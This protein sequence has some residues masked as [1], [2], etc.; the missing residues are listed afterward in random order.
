MSKDYEEFIEK[1]IARQ[2][3]AIENDMQVTIDVSMYPN[4][5]DFI[6]PIKG[7]IKEIN[8]YND[9]KIITF[10]TST[11]IQGEYDHAM[12]SVKKTIA[13]CHKKFSNAVYVIKV[14]PNYN[15]LD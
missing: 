3:N 7:F 1:N 10:P 12:D 4:K 14:I 6:P 2:N 11:V 8:K 15:A 13:A 5:E 9:L